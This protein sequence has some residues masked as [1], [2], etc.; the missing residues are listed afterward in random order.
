MI[1]SYVFASFKFHSWTPDWTLEATAALSGAKSNVL[2]LCTVQVCHQSVIRCVISCV[3]RRCVTSQLLKSLCHT[4]TYTL[5]LSYTQTLLLLSLSF[6]LSLGLFKQ[7]CITESEHV[8]LPQTHSRGSGSSTRVKGEVCHTGLDSS[9]L[10]NT[11]KCL[12]VCA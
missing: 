11:R 8:W 7:R 12:R 3:L 4:H 2:N 9:A 1:G 6:S 5:S 10:G